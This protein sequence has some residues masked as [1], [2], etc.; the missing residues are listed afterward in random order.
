MN[1][2]K[3]Q[4]RMEDCDSLPRLSLPEEVS[5][6]S[7]DEYSKFYRITLIKNNENSLITRE[8]ALPHRSK[9]HVSCH[10]GYTQSFHYSGPPIQTLLCER[11]R[12]ILTQPN[13]T[14]I[15][16]RKPCEPYE[17]YDKGLNP[18]IFSIS[19]VGTNEDGAK[20]ILQ[21]HNG[22]VSMEKMESSETLVC[23]H[24]VWDRRSL[25]CI[26]INQLEKSSKTENVICGNI[27]FK[28]ILELSSPSQNYFVKELLSKQ[29]VNAASVQNSDFNQPTTIQLWKVSCTRGYMPSEHSLPSITIAC[30]NK[31]FLS[32]VDIPVRL[33]QATNAV[34]QSYF[35]FYTLKKLLEQEKYRDYVFRL[36]YAYTMQFNKTQEAPA[37][38]SPITPSQPLSHFQCLADIKNL[39][40]NSNQNPHMSELLF[41]LILLLATF[42]FVAL[43]V[44]LIYLKRT[45]C[46]RR[47]FFDQQGITLPEVKTKCNTELKTGCSSNQLM[48]SSGNLKTQHT[49]NIRLKRDMNF[50]TKETAT[51]SNSSQDLSETQL[52]LLQSTYPKH[53]K[54]SSATHAAKKFY[55]TLP[56]T[57]TAQGT[58]NLIQPLCHKMEPTLHKVSSRSTIRNKRARYH[59]N[60]I[61]TASPQTSSYEDPLCST[62][63][64]SFDFTQGMCLH[65]FVISRLYYFLAFKHM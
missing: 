4:L 27:F 23:R 41:Y 47:P 63:R 56:T 19:S 43:I 44:I 57:T 53:K 20:R 51:N 1:T 34:D 31:T 49:S 50:E 28:N 2:L 64:E 42:A 18:L 45:N 24:G 10:R 3:S 15:V 40:Y 65:I 48:Q 58:L 54:K 55:N 7:F 29:V 39:A 33:T 38:I 9:L 17:L 59:P 61:N 62:F 16:C 36:Y 13:E 6:S 46:F 8:Q 25:D 11:G 21:C 37:W 35:S 60:T 12:W 30:I 22:Y 5:K 26:P 52:T 14:M 32:A